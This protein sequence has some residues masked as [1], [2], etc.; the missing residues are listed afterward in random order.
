MPA[1]PVKWLGFRSDA[2]LSGVWSCEDI[3][4]M[5]TDRLPSPTSSL[6]YRLGTRQLT[7]P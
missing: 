7:A 6:T 5:K 1:R 2:Q 4:Y 3:L